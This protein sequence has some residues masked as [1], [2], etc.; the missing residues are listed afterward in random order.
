M[1][2]FFWIYNNLKLSNSTIT[3]N[4]G[5]TCNRD[6]NAAKNIFLYG[7]DYINIDINI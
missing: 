5:I 7:N 4:C 2:I 1:R 3:C 6:E